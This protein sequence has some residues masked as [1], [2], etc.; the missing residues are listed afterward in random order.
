M[1]NVLF[2]VKSNELSDLVGNNRY[3][4]SGFYVCRKTNKYIEPTSKLY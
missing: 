4:G 1:L 3:Y 2:S